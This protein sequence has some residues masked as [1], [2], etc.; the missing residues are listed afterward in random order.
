[1]EEVPSEILLEASADFFILVFFV[2]TFGD[3][4][5]SGALPTAGL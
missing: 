4:G 1:M 2:E 5:A 3:T